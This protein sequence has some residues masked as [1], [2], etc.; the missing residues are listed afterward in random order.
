MVANRISGED[1]KQSFELFS[2]HEP[3]FLAEIGGEIRPALFEDRPRANIQE[4][5]NKFY[6]C[7]V[8]YDLVDQWTVKDGPF[9]FDYSWLA[10]RH[11]AP[12]VKTWADRHFRQIWGVS[13][14]DFRILNA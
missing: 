10:P 6:N 9:D 8:Q 14:D 1:A 12:A 11:P 2:R 3:P 13:V 7:V 5:F 4:T